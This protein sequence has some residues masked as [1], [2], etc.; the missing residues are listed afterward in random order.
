[1]KKN[2][3]YG[4]SILKTILAFYVIKTHFFRRNSIK[5]KILIFLFGKNRHIHVPC[6]FIMS[7]FFSYQYLISKDTKKIYKRFERLL[8]PYIFWPIIAYSINYIFN[9]YNNLKNRFTFNNLKTQLILGYGII[10][11]LWFQI[12]L[13]ATFVL[14][15]III[16]SFKKNYLFVFYFL[17][18]ISYLIEYSKFHL[19][20]FQYYKPLSVITIIREIMV[21]PFAV[22]GFS[23]GT[24]KIINKI[25]SL[26]FQVFIL[27]MII[28]ILVDCFGVFTYLGDYNGIELNILSIC[29]IF[30]FSLLPF[31]KIKNK[32]I[33]IIIQYITKY[34]PGIYYLHTTVHI[35]LRY[36]FSYIRKGTI[37]SII[38]NYIICYLICHIG[39]LLFGKT[40]ARNLFS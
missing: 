31:E 25:K 3:N 30:I 20:L 40:K 29:L 4:L 21:F 6:F 12:D 24:F 28:F 16:Y 22:I 1:M 9:K 32:Y 27:S 10:D 36:Y 11:P 18:I 26:R 13:I 19:Y 33:T 2:F 39:T 15:C 23:F 7:F 37:E 14:F 8:I 38:I 5:N 35:Y 34:T 17:M